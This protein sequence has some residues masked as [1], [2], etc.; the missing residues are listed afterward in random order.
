MKYDNHKDEWSRALHDK[1]RNKVAKTWLRDDNLDYELHMEVRK[2]V[3]PIIKSYPEASW[4]TIGDGRWGSDSIGLKKLGAKKVHAT[5]M[6][7]QLLKIAH[8]EK[9]LDTF[10]EEN[11]E[12][13]SFEDNSFDFVYCKD[14]LHHVPRPYIALDE[15]FRVAR[16]GVIFSE[17]L[18]SEISRPKLDFIYKAIKKFFNKS[19]N[20]HAFEEVGNY[21]YMFSP[22][23]IEKFLLGR[24]K[25]EYF[26]KKFD[27]I[28][29]KGV[30]FAFKSSSE[31]TYH[32]LSNNIN[33]LKLK[34][35]ILRKLGFKEYTSITA[36][37]PKEKI[38]ND[39][40]KSLI[41]NKWSA[42]KLPKNPYL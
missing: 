30:E 1:D 26:Y 9:L 36:F 40:V 39:C 28:Y 12:N 31:N 8:K 4:V 27:D 25:T 24:H 14:A 7:D 6:S 33:K 37:I 34:S 29:I 11:A 13:L 41:K 17:P 2:M 3:L 42:K 22:H 23:E 20:F 18:D 19:A 32:K 15:M 10:S 16:V 35:K 21:I 5:D 38:N